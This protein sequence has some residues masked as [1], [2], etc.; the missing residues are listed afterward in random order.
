[1]TEEAEEQGSRGAE[2][3]KKYSSA[4]GYKPLNLFME[5]IKY[6]FRAT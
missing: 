5:K 3:K 1:M 4:T 2:G 6:L